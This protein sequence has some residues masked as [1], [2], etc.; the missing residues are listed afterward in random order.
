M[1]DKEGGKFKMCVSL[2]TQIFFYCETRFVRS[3]DAYNAAGVSDFWTNRVSGEVLYGD[4][5]HSK[6]EFKSPEYKAGLTGVT[7]VTSSNITEDEFKE[8][9]LEIEKQT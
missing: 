8:G 7:C 3:T 4:A 9:K 6:I 2:F 5:W 1:A